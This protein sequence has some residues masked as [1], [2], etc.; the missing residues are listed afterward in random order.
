MLQVK[1]KRGACVLSSHPCSPQ[2]SLPS[3]E[4]ATT[5][6]TGKVGATTVPSKAWF[7]LLCRGNGIATHSTQSRDSYNVRTQNYIHSLMCTSKKSWWQ[8]V[9]SMSRTVMVHSER[10]CFSRQQRRRYVEEKFVKSGCWHSKI[11]KVHFLVEAPQWPNQCGTFNHSQLQ[12][13]SDRPPWQMSLPSTFGVTVITIYQKQQPQLSCHC[14]LS[15]W[16][17]TKESDM[18][19]PE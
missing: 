17:K 2:P 13:C 6:T 19:P 16:K 11:P 4:P 12:H 10:S 1:V 15:E 9:A 3:P 14:F 5:N 7:M 18:I 8:V